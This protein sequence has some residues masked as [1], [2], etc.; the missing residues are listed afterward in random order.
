MSLRYVCLQVIEEKRFLAGRGY[1]G[2]VFWVETQLVV[3]GRRRHFVVIQNKWDEVN[4]STLIHV[5]P[6]ATT[7]RCGCLEGH[8]ELP[9][10]Q[11]RR[12]GFHIVRREIKDS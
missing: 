6:H 4:Y 10:I 5:S 11:V 7:G 3:A 8:V 2:R 9:T 1:D 12:D